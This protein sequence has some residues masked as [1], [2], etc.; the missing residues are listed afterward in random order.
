MRLRYCILS[1]LFFCV[2]AQCQ[3]QEARRPISQK[4]GS[5]INESVARNKTLIAEEE[6]YIKK[7][8]KADTA[9][10]YFPTNNGFWYRYIVKDTLN[11]SMPQVG[12]QVSFY[13][14]IQSIN[15]RE[16]LSETKN[17]KQHYIIDKTNQELI[18]GI[19]E[20]LKL[21]KVGETVGFL[22]PSHLAYG[23]YGLEDYISSNIPVQAIVTLNSIE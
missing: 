20:G 8:I 2:F 3:Q 15:G 12:D 9:N 13:Y 5:F 22:L 6:A 17:G 4:S 16:I 1:L 10:T 21:M 18:T 7:L 14:S 23:Y 11:N 19:R